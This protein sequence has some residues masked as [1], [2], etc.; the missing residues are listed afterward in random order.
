MA[1]NKTQAQEH[2]CTVREMCDVYHLKENSSD[3]VSKYVKRNMFFNTLPSRHF[4]ENIFAD[5]SCR[6]PH[7]LDIAIAVRARGEVCVA[8]ALFYLLQNMLTPFSSSSSTMALE[9]KEE[10]QSVLSGGLSSENVF[11]HS[12]LSCPRDLWVLFDV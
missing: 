1:P 12:S 9:D 10:S 8:E 7:L 2:Q 6:N 5:L 11:L 4:C 3:D